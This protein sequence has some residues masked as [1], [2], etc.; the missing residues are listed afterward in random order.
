[1]AVSNSSNRNALMGLAAGALLVMLLALLVVSG[2]HSGQP[3]ARSGP[4]NVMQTN[5]GR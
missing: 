5:Q 4:G 3:S 2:G 1:M